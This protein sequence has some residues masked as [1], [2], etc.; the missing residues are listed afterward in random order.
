MRERAEQE[1]Q[2]TQEMEVARVEM[3]AA[4]DESRQAEREELIAAQEKVCIA[5][6][7]KYCSTAILI[8]NCF[9]NAEKFLI[10]KVNWLLEA[11]R[12]SVPMIVLIEFFI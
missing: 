5:N 11:K 2:F 8:K 6:V 1:E 7:S 12:A 4:I 3:R 10:L 9:G